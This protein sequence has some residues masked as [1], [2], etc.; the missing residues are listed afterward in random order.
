MAPARVCAPRQHAANLAPAPLSFTDTTNEGRSPHSGAGAGS[1]RA[2]DIT[3][4]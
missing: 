2:S 4:F 1:S 3:F